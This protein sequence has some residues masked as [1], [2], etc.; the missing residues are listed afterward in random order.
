MSNNPTRDYV[1]DID[2]FL[3]FQGNTG[4]YILYTLVRIK[5]IFEK[6]GYNDVDS[7]LNI[8]C[9]KIIHNIFLK[10]IRY[11]EVLLD[12]YKNYDP[13]VICK[14]IYELSND[15][16]S[17]YHDHNIINEQDKDKKVLYI[18]ICNIVDRIIRDALSILAIEIPNR[19]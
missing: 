15:F 17:F 9:D 19:M 4:P 11:E 1:F 8:N 18:I 7:Q 10:A 5:S 16:N 13:S 12:A 14:Y 2:K 6:I 3:S